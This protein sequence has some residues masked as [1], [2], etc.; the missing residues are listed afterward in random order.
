MARPLMNPGRVIW[1]GDHLLMSLRVPGASEEGT[2]ISCFRALYSPAGSGHAALVLSDVAGGLRAVYTDNEGMTAW[3]RERVTRRRNHALNDP[4]L[5]V[6]R[7]A[8]EASGEV[9]GEYRLVIRGEDHEV[10]VTWAGFEP[11]FH[12]E[13]PGAHPLAGLRAENLERGVRTGRFGDG[14]DIFTL[15]CPARSGGVEVDG[16]RAAGDPYPREVWRPS[17]GRPLSSA[18][19]ALCEVLIE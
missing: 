18:L 11:P 3:V 12:A 13:G 1:A 19:I 16:R 4:G 5:P 17:M 8:F 15:L 14:Y 2:V 6:R 10:G 9:G 7:A